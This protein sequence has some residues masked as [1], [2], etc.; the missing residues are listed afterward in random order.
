M[1]KAYYD[2]S[3]KSDNPKC[4]AITLAG[5]AAS[6]SVWQK[7]EIEWGKVLKEYGIKWVHMTDLMSFGH[8]F[9]RRYG[10]DEI[11]R[12]QLIRE[13]L[14]VLGKLRFIEGAAL[15]SNLMASTCTVLM[16]DYRRALKEIPKLRIPEAICVRFCANMI[17]YDI[18]VDNGGNR[19]KLIMI[20]D[21][22][23]DFLHTIDKNWRKPK[24]KADAG[25][26][27]QIECI[28]KVNSKDIKP[29]QAA[30]F[31][32]WLVNKKD[33]EGK[34]SPY[35]LVISIVTEHRSF[36]YN[37]NTIKETFPNG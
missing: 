23:E 2:G 35:S 3:G 27:K 4:R 29:L 24:K 25:W 28:C 11:K 30:D 15:G 5:L 22:N 8:E 19:P 6:E 21:Q 36:L 9:S 16:E 18:D 31:F 14:G 10:W 32:A 26:P 1:I 12:S 7:F 13:L 17:P 37:Y 34:Q 20:F 33:K